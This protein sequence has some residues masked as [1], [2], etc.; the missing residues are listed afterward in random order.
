V[1]G[2]QNQ[3]LP[4]LK[5]G[6]LTYNASAAWAYVPVY[7]PDYPSN[8]GLIEW[9][10]SPEVFSA[11]VAPT[12]ETVTIARII[13]LT[14][15]SI[16]NFIAWVIAAGSGL[17]APTTTNI[18]ATANNGSRE[19][20]LTVGSSAAFATN[21]ICT[22]SGT[23]FTNGAFPITVVDA[24]HV[25]LQ[26]STFG[27]ADSAGTLTRSAC[28][29]AIYDSSGNFISCT[30]DLST[31]LTATGELVAPFATKPVLVADDVYYLVLLYEGSSL[32]LAGA[33]APLGLANVGMTGAA[34][35]WASNGTGATKLPFSITPASNVATNAVPFWAALS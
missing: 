33:P 1:T 4:T 15:G 26:G 25:D 19:V 7:D 13:A 14:G 16:T 31:A 17:A 20:R 18:S 22:V 35:R 21:N 3:A 30:G 29:A 24:T 6:A 28:V 23:T 27:S 5:P 9:V 12:S 2:I 11:S 34:L 8:H 32:E 10:G